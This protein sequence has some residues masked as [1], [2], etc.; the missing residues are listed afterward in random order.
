MQKLK[1]TKIKISKIDNVKEE[2]EKLFLKGL[3]DYKIAKILNIDHS[4]IFQYRK[5]HGYIRPSLREA[6]TIPLTQDNIEILLGTLM[7]DSSLSKKQINTRLTCEHGIKQKEYCKYKA[8]LLSNLNINFKYNKRKTADKRNGKYYE[9]CIL[10]SKSNKALNYLYDAFYHNNKKVIPF[11]LLNNFTA[12]SL[13]FMFMDDG[14]KISNGYAL[15]TNCF[16]EEEIIK[17]RKFLFNKFNLETSMFKTHI[18]YIHKK[19]VKIFNSL[20]LPYICEC[21]KYKLHSL[22]TS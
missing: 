12:K 2:F 18:I 7:G 22:I 3:S 5:K 10:R 4:T 11:E 14:Y 17:F 19:S 20:V 8:D 1:N 21:M 6:K 16:T 13:A 9:S 15:S